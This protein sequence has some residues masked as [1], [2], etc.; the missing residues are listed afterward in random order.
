MS[1]A[2]KI[3]T[4]MSVQICEHGVITLC[5]H[6]ENGDI[7]AEASMDVAGYS[8]LAD[9]VLAQFE[10]LSA[11]DDDDDAIGKCEGHA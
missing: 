4:S 6:D 1:K 3:A 7:F 9:D 10:E 8:A 11:D 2:P 5:L